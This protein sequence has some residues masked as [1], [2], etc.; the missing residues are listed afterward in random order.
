MFVVLTPEKA[1]VQQILFLQENVVS[2][3]TS[4]NCLGKE[5]LMKGEMR[6]T[7]I[8]IHFVI[9]VAITASVLLENRF[10]NCAKL[11][12]IHR[13]CC[14]LLLWESEEIDLINVP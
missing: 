5:I 8:W 7:C 3:C 11:F 13:L 12:C 1:S 4:K 10:S 9:T 2:T 6:K 14:L